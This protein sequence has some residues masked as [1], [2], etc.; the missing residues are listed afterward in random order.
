MCFKLMLRPNTNVKSTILLLFLVAIVIL[1]VVA[2]IG[3]FDVARALALLIVAVGAAASA[4]VSLRPP[5]FLV[6]TKAALAIWHIPAAAPYDSALLQ[7]SRAP[8][9]PGVQIA[10]SDPSWAP[11]VATSSGWSMCGRPV[12]P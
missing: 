6:D 8:T 3:L 5:L 1:G 10:A 12:C 9:P 7:T 2:R 11:H 4:G